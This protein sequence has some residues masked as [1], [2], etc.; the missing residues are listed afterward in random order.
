MAQSST[1]KP[2]RRKRTTAKPKAEKVVYSHQSRI[3]CGNFKAQA[4]HPGFMKPPCDCI[5]QAVKT[6][7]DGRVKHWRCS[8]GNT[9]TTEGQAI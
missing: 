1:K 4:S 7:D 3:K 9:R 6:T 8:C 5:M 2:T